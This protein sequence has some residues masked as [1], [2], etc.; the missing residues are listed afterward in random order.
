MGPKTTA[1]PD[2]KLFQTEWV[3]LIAQRHELVKLAKNWL[4][5]ALGDA[6]HSVLCGAWHNPRMILRRLRALYCASMGVMTVA[7]MG[8]I[9]IAIG[10]HRRHAN[11]DS[12]MA[13]G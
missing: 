3:N 2:Q 6:M 10:N 11:Q 13:A 12:L 1:F 7:L 4:K 5:G 8:V 9:E